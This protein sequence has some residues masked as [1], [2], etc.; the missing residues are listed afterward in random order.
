MINRQEDLPQ[1]SREKVE[2]CHQGN[3]KKRVCHRQNIRGWSPNLGKQ[4][5]LQNVGG[6]G[7]ASF[8]N[9]SPYIYIHV[10]LIQME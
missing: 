6:K 1:D 9:I 7:K 5:S 8:G 2:E 3:T 4:L 10:E